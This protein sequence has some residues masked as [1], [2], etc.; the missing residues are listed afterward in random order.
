MRN[1]HS[2]CCVEFCLDS[3]CSGLWPKNDVLCVYVVRPT[4]RWVLF[5]E[6]AKCFLFIF[7]WW[8]KSHTLPKF[9]IRTTQCGF[10]VCTFRCHFLWSVLWQLA[11]KIVV[12]LDFCKVNINKVKRICFAVLGLC[13]HLGN[14]QEYFGVNDFY[15]WGLRMGPSVLS[16]LYAQT[17]H[18]CALHAN[19]MLVECF[20]DFCALW[21]SWF[22]NS[23]MNF[24][25]IWVFSV[26][27]KNDKYNLSWSWLISGI[28]DLFGVYLEK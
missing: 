3:S 11:S 6:W 7:R 10:I 1:P 5:C 26:S 25:Q 16:K 23:L 13:M 27:W 14:C 20:C 12:S 9:I 24:S 22:S 18:C 2:M 8:D 21:L 19:L 4:K 17:L 15:V 28:W